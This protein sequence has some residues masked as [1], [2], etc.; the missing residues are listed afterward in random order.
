M[1]IFFDHQAFSLQDAGGVSRYQYE[2]IRNLQ[3]SGEV[4]T[5]VVMGL[6]AS[7]LPFRELHTPRT[8]ILTWKTSLRPGYF[9]YAVNEMISVVRAQSLGQFDIYHV[10]LY[11]AIPYVHRGRLVATH[12][13]CTH[14]RFPHLFHN[15]SFIMQRKRKLFAQ[16][17]AIICVSQSSRQDLLHFY[18]VDEGK[19]HVV[20]HGFSPLQLDSTPSRGG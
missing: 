20:H 11:R 2:L 1:R 9:R 8:R 4:R 3:S 14:E 17:D 15:A 10:M 12:H 16:A 6:N 13:D 18:D 19:T 7:V 5:E